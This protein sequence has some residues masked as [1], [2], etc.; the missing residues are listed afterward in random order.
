MQPSPDSQAPFVFDLFVRDLARSLRFY[1]QLGFAIERSSGDFAVL[2][3]GPDRLFL[4]AAPTQAPDPAV[5]MNLRLLVPDVDA[6]WH[7]V[8]AL[9][10]RVHMAIGDR[11]Y[12]LRDFTIL[13]PDGYG[14][15]FAGSLPFSG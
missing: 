15:R 9:D 7:R 3:W 10:C 13:D 11:P 5:R 1:T 14:V 6:C 8:Q 2:R 12:G 4:A